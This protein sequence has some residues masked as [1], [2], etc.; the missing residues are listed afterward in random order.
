MFVSLVTLCLS[1]SCSLLVP[2]SPAAMVRAAAGAVRAAR[3]RGESRLIVRLIVPTDPAFDQP[4]DLDPWPGGLKQQYPIALGL[5]RELMS[6]AVGCAADAVSDQVVDAEDACGLLNAQAASAA[7][8][9]ACLLF[10]GPDQ[11]TAL[12]KMD[13]AAGDRLLVLINP[14][15]RRL[16]SPLGAARRRAAA[17]FFDRGY[18]TAFAFEEFAAR[19]ED[20]KL[21]GT[22]AGGW[23][24]F[25]FL[26]DADSSGQPLFGG[27]ARPTRPTY[28]ELERAINAEHPAPRWAR[29]LDEVDER[30]LA[31]MRRSGNQ[32]EN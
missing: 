29:K 31:F 27:E 14:Q 18:V 28:E 19:G 22:L 2:E 9:A 30:G 3:E 23:R 21:V 16:C 10:P 8:D 15:F 5:A 11:L 6:A 7:D 1:M 13:A 26:H 25:V 24:A 32:P 17:T 12:E 20:V 4:A